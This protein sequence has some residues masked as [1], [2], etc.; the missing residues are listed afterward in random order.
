MFTS[1]RNLTIARNKR[2]NR[3]DVKVMNFLQLLPKVIG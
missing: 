2:Y 3:K 1:V